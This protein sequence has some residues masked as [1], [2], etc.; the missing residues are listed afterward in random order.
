MR[1]FAKPC[2]WLLP[3]GLALGSAPA[4]ARGL[5]EARLRQLATRS[6][7]RDSWPL[8]QRYAAAA[9]GAEERGLAYFVLGYRE[10]EAG[11]HLKAIAA[12][13]EAAASRFSLADFAEYYQ[14]VAAEAENQPRQVVEILR[15]FSTSHPTS[16]LRLKALDLLVRAFLQTSDPERAIQALT[17]E[18]RVRQI[19]PLALLLSQAYLKAEKL[20]EAARAFQEVYYA[21][22]TAPESDAASDALRRLEAQLGVNFPSASEEIQ[23]ARAEILLNKSQAMR[24]LEEYE[25]LLRLRPDSQLAGRWVLG[26]ARCL[27]SLKRAPEAVKVLETPAPVHPAIDAE[28][29]ATLVEAEARQGDEVLMLRTL[30]QLRELYSQSPSYAA[31]LSLA[32]SFFERRGEWESAVPYD[33]ILAE[34]FPDSDLGREGHWRVA[35]TF[36]LTRQDDRARQALLV[37]VARYP[38]SPHIP[39]A[40][41]WLGRLSEGRQGIPE[42]RTLYEFLSLHFVHSYYALLAGQRLQRLPSEPADANESPQQSSL[43]ALEHV[44]AHLGPHPVQPCASAEPSEEL[45]PSMTLRAVGLNNL[46]EEYLNAELSER[47]DAPELL[48]ALSKLN[49]GRR[50]YN[51]AL[52]SAKKLLPNASEYHFAE[53][54][55]EIWGL[56]YPQ[57]F[58]PLVERQAR[59]NRLSP[60]L[61]MGMIRDESGFNP[62]ATS[63]A[64]ARGLMQILPE[65]AG[66]TP[67]GRR[68]AAQKLYDP[69]Y[70]LRFGCRYLRGLLRTYN[71]SPEQALAAYHAGTPNVR[72]WREGRQFREPG[73]FVEAIPIAATRLYVEAVLRDAEIYRQLM[74]RSA[75]FKKCS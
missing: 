71:G 29:L 24:A 59:A 53:L 26:R 13:R 67:R 40:L 51:V 31:A 32:A 30:N 35:W 47:P 50:D 16:S 55:Q 37:H 28:R 57:A 70:N 74:T 63:W 18:L 44:I 60:Y 21:F 41:Y 3:I 10:Y 62:R 7:T 73:E 38:T 46:A 4:R 11:Q 15:D 19:S 48:L 52:V 36:Y 66:S 1:L 27:L 49:E 39:A 42:A 17:A 34:Q 33:Q 56:L 14:A 68:L 25:S 43:V 61:V 72:T 22:P 2:A 54:P 12:L 58:R 45:R 8:L 69:A 6:K 64:N 23:T 75:K 65:T 5:V 20:Q 9:N